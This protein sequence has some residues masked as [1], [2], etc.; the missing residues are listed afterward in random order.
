MEIDHCEWADKIIETQR[1]KITEFKR[2]L[3]EADALCVKLAH[4]NG[5]QVDEIRDLKTRLRAASE[6]FEENCARCENFPSKECKGC[7]FFQI[8]KLLGFEATLGEAEEK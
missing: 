3:A 8:K 2:R 4:Q 1:E 7:S 6:Y 5:G